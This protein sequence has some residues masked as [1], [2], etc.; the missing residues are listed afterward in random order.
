M[1]HREQHIGSYQ[2]P[3]KQLRAVEDDG[4]QVA[5]ET[6]TLRWKSRSQQDSCLCSWAH[7]GLHSLAGQLTWLCA[8]SVHAAGLGAVPSTTCSWGAGQVGI[9]CYQKLMGQ[10][11]GLRQA[12]ME[13]TWGFARVVSFCRD[14]LRVG[15][16]ACLGSSMQ[17]AGFQATHA[18]TGENPPRLNVNFISTLS[19]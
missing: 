19:S 1:K 15:A 14:S 13:V 5:E 11:N 3:L 18:F 8:P 17:E 16:Q 2:A 9:R 10:S 7:H 4:C 6:L 12:K